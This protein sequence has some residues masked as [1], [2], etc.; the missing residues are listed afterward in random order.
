MQPEQPIDP[1]KASHE[2]YIVPAKKVRSVGG[3]VRLVKCFYC[4]SFSSPGRQLRTKI[5]RFFN[6]V[7][8]SMK[9]NENVWWYILHVLKI[10][11]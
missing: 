10:I 7:K 11:L 2:S 4:L 3:K 9:R 8:C 1:V 6:C 5:N